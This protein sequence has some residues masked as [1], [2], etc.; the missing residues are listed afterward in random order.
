M[1]DSVEFHCVFLPPNLALVRELLITAAS[2][3]GVA[4]IPWVGPSASGAVPG[5]GPGGA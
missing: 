5:Q 2:G 4:G 3:E 1:A